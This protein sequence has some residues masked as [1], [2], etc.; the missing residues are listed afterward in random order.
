MHIFMMEKKTINGNITEAIFKI[1]WRNEILGYSVNYPTKGI[2]YA[3]QYYYVELQIF[4][5]GVC[6]EITCQILGHSLAGNV[7]KKG[8]LHQSS[9]YVYFLSKMKILKDQKQEAHRPKRSPGYQR[10]HTSFL[11]KGLI[12]VYLQ[13]HHRIN[14]NQLWYQ[15]AAS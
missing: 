8:N 12:F 2:F 10:L 1:L 11:S 4:P 15:K 14:E 6:Y 9:M 3:R 5:P 13:P 7:N